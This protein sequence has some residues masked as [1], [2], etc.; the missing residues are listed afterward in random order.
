MRTRWDRR[1]KLLLGVA[2]AVLGLLLLFG[3]AWGIDAAIHGDL[4]RRNVAL[5][6]TAVGGL[7]E[8]DLRMVVEDMAEAHAATPVIVASPAVVLETTAATAGLAIDVD[9]TVE[10]V[11]GIDAGVGLAAR[12]GRWLGSL[13]EGKTVQPVVTVDDTA[14][15]AVL[16]PLADANTEESVEP[17]I[18][19]TDGVVTVVPGSEGR[20][21][22]TAEV[23]AAVTDATDR[24]G[25]V[26]VEVSVEPSV[27]P[28]RWSDGDAQQVAAE[29]N[30]L[31]AEPITVIVGEQSVAV[32]PPTMRS[33]L[34]A[35]PGPDELDLVID[36]DRVGEDLDEL[37]GGIGS[38][39]VELAWFVDGEGRP[40]YTEGTPGA[41]CCAPDST[42][43]LIEGL[44]SGAGT[45]ELAFEPWLPRHD[46][47][48]AESMGIVEPI[49]S[50]TTEH[51][52]CQNRVR[53]IHR[54][55]DLTRGVVI[56]PGGTFSVN[57]HVGRRT[58]EGGFFS[59]AVIY[60][61]RLTEDVGGG[62]S[63][64]ATT[65]FN[66]AFFAGL[67]IPAY[68]MH[69]LYISRYPYGREATLSHPQPDLQVRN[70]TDHGVLLWPT[71]TD[72]SITVTLY[73]TKTIEADQTGQVR[74][75]AGRCTGVETERTRTWLATGE[76]RTDTF[77]ATYQ[78]ADGVLC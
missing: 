73:S 53:N 14:L 10:E 42:E 16:E 2:G 44:R 75:P 36:E 68:Q 61:G 66:A 8:N 25:W 28:P 22:D 34:R 24:A 35:E 56:E 1:D 18:T 62:V 64:Y 47:A 46:A 26:P 74:F 52:C 40:G 20:Q 27:I 54:I 11:M 49:G 33:W 19:V 69:T 4:V 30:E 39:P 5:V 6:D 15:L 63:Q 78:P 48:W 23:A 67:D 65:L 59:D 50:F 60:N 17:T 71:Y 70:N 38:P 7:S 12:P 76:Q 3:A 41:R 9:A 13:V 57:D 37:V 43:R 21:L 45:V 77:R 72:T 32:P 55:A 58:V 31:T 51:A 29:A